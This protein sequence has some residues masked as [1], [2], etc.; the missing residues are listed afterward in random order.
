MKQSLNDY[1]TKY[2]WLTNKDFY[3]DCTILNKPFGDNF[4]FT[5]LILKHYHHILSITGNIWVRAA[6]LYS[7]IVVSNK[8]KRKGESA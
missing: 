7:N 2:Q 3:N 8:K 5:T 4:F 6:K 1:V